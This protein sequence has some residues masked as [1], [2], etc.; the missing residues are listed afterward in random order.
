MGDA[1][2]F[3]TPWRFDVE[4]KIAG[5]FMSGVTIVGVLKKSRFAYT[6]K[7]IFIGLSLYKNDRL[8]TT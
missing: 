4:K 6:F 2:L 8:Y 3:A 1:I 5:G 7:S